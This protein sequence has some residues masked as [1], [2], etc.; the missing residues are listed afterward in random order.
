MAAESNTVI[1]VKGLEFSHLIMHLMVKFDFFPFSSCTS[2]LIFAAF[3]GLKV[4]WLVSKCGIVIGKQVQTNRELFYLSWFL[5]YICFF[6]KFM[7]FFCWV[8]RVKRREIMLY[9]N[10]GV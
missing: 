2:C 4:V 9:C 10:S 8:F 7:L 3:L 1:P 6:V 5:L